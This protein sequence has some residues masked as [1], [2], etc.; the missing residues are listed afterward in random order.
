MSHVSINFRS[1]KFLFN[2]KEVKQVKYTATCVLEVE[3]IVHLHFQ[4]TN[5]P[6]P[7]PW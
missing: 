1:N 3:H 6:V 4:E 2:G 5:M 7:V